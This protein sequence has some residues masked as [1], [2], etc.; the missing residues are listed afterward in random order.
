MKNY[1]TAL[2]AA[3]GL[4]ACAGAEISEFNT[5]NITGR[6]FSQNAS[7]VGVALLGDPGG[8]SSDA[9]T[10][11]FTSDTNVTVNVGGSSLFLT[12]QPDDTYAD[13]GGTNVLAVGT[14]LQDGPVTPDILYF[15]LVTDQTSRPLD[16]MFFVDGNRT[17]LS[18][19]PSSFATYTGAVKTMNQNIEFGAGTINLNVDFA[20]GQVAGTLSGVLPGNPGASMSIDP[21][22]LSGTSFGST[23]SSADVTINSSSIDGQFFGS[24]ADQVGGGLYLETPTEF[25]GGLY[26]ATR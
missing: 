4:S 5:S 16:T 18:G 14:L 22:N 9:V 11:S 2:T 7:T 26:G 17:S 20:G 1:A 10:V 15:T 3:I 6:T 23:L 25:V 12:R 8:V 19:L 21:T 24:N 13:F